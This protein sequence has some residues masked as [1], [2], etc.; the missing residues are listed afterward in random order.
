MPLDY[1]EF[2][3]KV[4]SKY[5]EYNDVDDLTLAKKMIEKYPEYKNEVT[6]EPLKKKEVSQSTQKQKATSLDGSNKAT[7]Q[8]SVSSNQQGNYSLPGEYLDYPGKGIRRYYDGKWY[9]YG[10]TETKNGKEFSVYNKDITDPNRI[11]TLNKKFNKTASLDPIDKVY[12]NYDEEKKD[13]QYRINNGNWERKVPGAMSWSTVTNEGSVGAL[14]RRYG[15]DV[16]YKPELKTVKQEPKLQFADINTSLVSKTEENAVDVLAKKYSKYGFTFEQTGFGT[17]YVTVYN[18]DKSKELTVGFDEKN[19]EEALKL[20]N[21]LEQNA[22][23]EN[24]SSYENIQSKVSNLKEKYDTGVKVFGGRESLINRIKNV[25][26]K[27][28]SNYYETKEYENDFKSLTYNEMKDEIKNR[29][30]WIN[31]NVDVYKTRKER[32]LDKFKEE[33][34]MLLENEIISRY[35]YQKGRAIDAFRNDL[36]VNKAKEI[37]ENKKEYNTILKK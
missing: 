34:K 25:Y 27:L 31:A 26:D 13:N 14:N 17:D 11:T 15:K 37:L 5:P 9:D 32:D 20:R 16:K 8:Q 4:K 21:F 24:S 10:F 22:S 3:K 28:N 2:A 33:I 19:P 30:D 18:K 12:S 35:Y 29:I 6:F 36:F 7:K 23:K 1:I